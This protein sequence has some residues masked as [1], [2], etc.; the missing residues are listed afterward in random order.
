MQNSLFGGFD[1][2]IEIATP[3]IPKTDVRWSDIERLNKERDLVGI[4]LS[5]HPL[6]E[7][8]IVL[9]NLCNTK[10]SEL[11]SVK[12]SNDREDVVVGGIVTGVRTGF[13]KIGKPFGI[14]TIEDFEGSGELAL[15]GEAWGDKSGFFSVGASIYVTAKLKPR[16][17]F[18]ENSPKDLKVMTVEYLQ[19]VKD[20]AIDRITISMNTDLLNE[21]VVAELQEFI[22]EHPGKTKLFF[23]L[24]DSQGKHHVLLRSTLHDIDVRHSLIDYIEHQQALDYKIN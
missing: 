15:F 11:E 9:D 10:C 16:F 4:Y 2:G 5:A 14:V 23:Q 8:K 7:Y 12:S 19:T 21:Q 1:D 17:Q 18:Q 13:T 3:P 6:D 20:K 24:R 22:G